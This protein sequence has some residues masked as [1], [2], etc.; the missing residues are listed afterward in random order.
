MKELFVIDI[1]K[2]LLRESNLDEMY[3]DNNDYGGHYSKTGNQKIA[4]IIYK[5]ISD[6]KLI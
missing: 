4:D 2:D 3:S 1:S 5:K 6:L